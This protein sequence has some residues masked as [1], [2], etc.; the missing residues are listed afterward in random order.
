[1]LDN[2]WPAF[3]DALDALYPNRVPATPAHTNDLWQVVGQQQVAEWVRRWVQEN[4]MSGE[5]V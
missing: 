4:I 1:M 2:S 3:L 5:P